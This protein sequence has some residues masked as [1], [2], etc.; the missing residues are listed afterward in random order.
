MADQVEDIV[1]RCWDH[2]RSRGP[3]YFSMSPMF[4]FLSDLVQIAKAQERQ[5]IID[6]LPR[7]ERGHSAEWNEGYNA[8]ITAVIQL[9]VQ[10]S[11]VP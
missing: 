6:A 7:T 3:S 1:G 2:D 10:R 5:T 4:A 9:L 11:I 8:A